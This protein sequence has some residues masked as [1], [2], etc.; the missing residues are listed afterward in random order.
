MAEHEQVDVSKVETLF[1]ERKPRLVFL[2]ACYGA[3]LG[4]GVGFSTAL[5]IVKAGVPAVVAMQYDIDA[6]SADKF[7]STST[8]S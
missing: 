7:A 5:E 6:E 2:Q 4:R 3:A 1:R 8:T